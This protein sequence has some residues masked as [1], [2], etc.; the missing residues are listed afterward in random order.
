MSNQEVT[1]NEIMGFLEKNMVTRAEFYD[2]KNDTEIRFDNLEG[3]VGHLE[4]QMVTKDYLDDKFAVFGAEIGQKIYR[5]AERTNTL[6][7]I[8]ADKSILQEA[9]VLKLKN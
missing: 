3:R 1:T 5:Q 8:L 7:E 9:D 2:F 4:N 6:V